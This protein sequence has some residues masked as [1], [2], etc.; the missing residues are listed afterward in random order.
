MPKKKNYRIKTPNPICE[1]CFKETQKEQLFFINEKTVCTDCNARI[2]A[3][4]VE[5]TEE[6]KE[7]RRWLQ[8]P[9]AGHRGQLVA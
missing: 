2:R 5:I 9:R 4:R 3:R 1:E 6:D 7:Y 8:S